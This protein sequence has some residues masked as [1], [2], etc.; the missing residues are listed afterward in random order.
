MK[1]VVFILSISLW[2]LSSIAQDK[3]SMK[4]WE[5]SL[6]SVA[7][8]ILNGE[9]D[10]VK[11]AAHGQFKQILK[12]VLQKKESL[13]HPFNKLETIA[14]LE[15]SDKSFRIFN[16][17]LPRDDGTFEYFG[18][19][20]YYDKKYKKLQVVELIDKSEEV[21]SGDQKIMSAKNWYGAHYYTV[22]GM[23][24][25]KSKYYLL[26]GWD[27][28]NRMTNKKII[29]VLSFGKAGQPIFGKAVL[30][31]P[32]G[33]VNRLVIEYHERAAMTVKFKPSQKLI[34]Y[35]HLSGN[36]EAVSGAAAFQGPD[37]SYDAL[38]YKRGK[39]Q[40]VKDYD[41][42]NPKDGKKDNYNDPE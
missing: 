15:P 16:W 27:G 35:D 24:K 31:T 5:D 26:L 25:K 12:A 41:A 2:T 18:F 36:T 11:Y 8:A 6:V 32:L 14:I 34:I 21:E 1:R 37:G 38:R 42:R 40:Y 30:G 28:N 23:K 17:N 10:S 22:I 9:N 3:S 4:S 33:Y 7:P 39:W 20:H 13:K 29:D 19:I